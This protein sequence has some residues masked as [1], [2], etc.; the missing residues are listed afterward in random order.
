MS[1]ICFS[2]LQNVWETVLGELM[3]KSTCLTEQFEL[4]EILSLLNFSNHV[5]VSAFLTQNIC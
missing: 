5:I 3:V 2:S 1:K 4:S